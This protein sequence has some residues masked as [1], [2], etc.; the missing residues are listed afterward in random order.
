MAPTMRVI[1]QDEL[2]GP[3]VLHIGERPVPDPLPTE[4][5]VR[6]QAAGVNPVDW[7]TR[8]GRGMAGVLGDPPF[9]V[10]WDVAGVVDAVGFG[11]TRLAE[12]DRVFGM[13]WFPRQAAAY[14]E[15]VTAPSRHF[16]RLADDVDIVTAGATPLAALTA[17]Q[18][19]VDAADVQPGQ[20]VLVHA[21]AGGVGHLAVQIAKVRGATVLGTASAAKHDQLTDL[22]VDEPIDYRSVAFEEVAR[23]V[24]VVVDLIGGEYGH[25]S[26]RTLRPGGLLVSVPSG[27]PEGLPEAARAAGVRSTSFLVEPDGT[28]LTGIARLLAEGSLRVLVDAS[29]SLE[30]A[31]D[32]HAAGEQGRNTGKLVLTL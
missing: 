26:L 3:E 24:D 9:T 1:T 11:V 23:D 25:R 13:P 17:W 29:Y 22:G 21:A 15:Y 30:K 27:Q 32:A 31:A 18:V 6:V 19:L 4:V 2:G 12:G 16:A 14:A 8:A 20:R 5:R 10:G 28:A 7:K